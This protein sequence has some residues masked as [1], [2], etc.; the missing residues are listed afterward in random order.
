MNTE[1]I[2]AGWRLYN[3][4]KKWL[5]LIKKEE[6]D[7]DRDIILVLATDSAEELYSAFI[8]ARYLV[9]LRRRT[10]MVYEKSGKIIVISDKN[11]YERFA[12]FC[13]GDKLIYFILSKKDKDN[14]LRY[15]TFRPSGKYF[16][17]AS[18]QEPFGRNCKEVVGKNGITIFELY[19]NG[20][21]KLNI[22]DV[23]AFFLNTTMK[24]EYNDFGFDMFYK[25][26]KTVK[27]SLEK[28]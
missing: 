6:I 9:N 13:F 7:L 24:Y 26:E 1:M 11:Q 10:S 25:G 28:N 19:L 14:M 17:I 21:F 27:C 4:R 12:E 15:Y 16:F 3:G 2:R 22:S 5:N 8:V 23:Y 18:L 20:I